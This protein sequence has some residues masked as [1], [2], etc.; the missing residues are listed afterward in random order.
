LA[1]G[2]DV[3]EGEFREGEAVGREKP[4]P[5]HRAGAMSAATAKIA[6]SSSEVSLGRLLVG[7]GKLTPA[8]LDRAERLHAESGERLDAILT[9]LGLVS[10]SSRPPIFPRRRCS[11]A[12]SPRAF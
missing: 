12:A 3:D 5:C 11:R 7:A 9:K 8:A 1:S 4:G 6:A 2:L 10:R